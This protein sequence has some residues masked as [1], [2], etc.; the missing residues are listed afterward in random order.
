MGYVAL[1]RV[2]SLTGLKLM[3]LNE[4]ALQ[5]HPKILHQD[6]VFQQ[7]S[8]AAVDRVHQCSVDQRQE[9]QLEV[10]LERFEG[11]RKPTN[12]QPSDTPHKQAQAIKKSE[13]SATKAYMP[14]TRDD[15]EK[16]IQLH[17]KKIPLREL[18]G[19]FQ[20]GRGAIRSRLKKLEHK[21]NDELYRHKQEEQDYHG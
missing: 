17:R 14:W 6:S 2:R 3:G 5:V 8:L 10:L 20:R 18:A 19:I 16:L 13:P 7:W 4:M 12:K 15:D 1:S 11:K 21:T 9:R